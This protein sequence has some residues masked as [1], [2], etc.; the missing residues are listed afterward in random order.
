MRKIILLLILILTNVIAY[1]QTS[2]NK[3]NLPE[4]VII[5]SF[6]DEMDGSAALLVSKKLICL[7]EDESIGFA[8][9]PMINNDFS[10][11]TL[12]TNSFRIGECDEKSELTFLFEDGSNLKLISFSDFDCQGRSAFEILDSAKNN[13]SQKK[14]KK[15]RYANGRTYESYTQEVTK[16]SEY[17]IFFFKELESKKA[18]D[19]KQ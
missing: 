14:I 19:Y 2:Y 16:E 7:K 15:I 9:S 6:K 13:L 1:S 17:F 18:F 4:N 8:I 3:D 11:N 10:C 12:V 5:L